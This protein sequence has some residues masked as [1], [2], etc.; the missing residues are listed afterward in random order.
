MISPSPQSSP[1]KGRGSSFVPSP[2]MGEILW[3]CVKSFFMSRLPIDPLGVVGGAV[4]SQGP[5]EPGQFSGHG[6]Q[7]SGGAQALR[8][9]PLVLGLKGAL[10]G[11][12]ACLRAQV[13]QTA[14][15]GISLFG[16]GS[17]APPLAR[18][19]HPDIQT[20]ISHEG[21]G[22][23][24]GLALHTEGDRGCGDGANPRNTSQFLGQGP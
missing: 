13:Q 23:G 1:T 15:F 2:S 17:V 18:V 14:Q 6:T 12:Q 21:I 24:E 22:M 20:A 3:L 11:A 9:F 16:Q 8:P 19:P 10:G 5:A 7:G 4:A